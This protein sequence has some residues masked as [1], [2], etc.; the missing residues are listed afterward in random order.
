VD[1]LFGSTDLLVTPV[2]G[3]SVNF[4]SG[5]AIVQG[6]LYELTD[7]PLNKT[8]S[9]NGG[10]TNRADWAVL[11]YDSTHTPGVYARVLTGTALTQAEDGVWDMPL[12]SWLKTPA[13][14]ITSFV[15]RRPFRPPDMRVCT[16]TTRPLSPNRGDVIYETDTGQLLVRTGTTWAAV[17]EDTGWVAL[18][19]NSD[20]GDAW[21]LNNSARVRKING[22]VHVRFSIQRW[23]TNGLGTADSDGSAPITLPTQFRPTQDEFGSA[24]H[25]R[26]PVMVRVETTG[27]VRLFPLTADIPASRTVQG[28]ATYMTG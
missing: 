11:T 16:S 19:M 21:S 3:T 20:D 18:S 23:S 28:S 2:G 26:S 14:A 7:G 10:S 12:A 22:V 27:L 15:D 6:A 24:F 17:Y 13:G 4:N 25:S 8:V 5:R 9:A 1:A